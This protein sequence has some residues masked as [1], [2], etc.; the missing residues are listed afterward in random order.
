MCDEPLGETS[1]E[2][3]TD[4]HRKLCI[5]QEC[6]DIIDAEIAEFAPF[7]LGEFLSHHGE[8]PQPDFIAPRRRYL[9]PDEVEKRA[10]ARY[11]K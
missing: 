9:D 4:Y 7:F 8:S 3:E 5:C 11:Y 1:L 6:Q 10:R 2:V